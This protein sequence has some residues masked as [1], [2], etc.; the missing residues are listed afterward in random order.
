MSAGLNPLSFVIDISDS[1]QIITQIGCVQLKREERVTG[2]G[3]LTSLI[4]SLATE[5]GWVGWGVVYGMTLIG[6]Y[7]E[8]M[9]AQ[10]GLVDT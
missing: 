2:K 4:D 6:L 5:G 8:P 1:W 7:L 10:G 3:T 9:C